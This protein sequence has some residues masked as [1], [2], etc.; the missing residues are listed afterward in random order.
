MPDSYI[1]GLLGG[2]LIGLGSL[3]AMIASGK[4]PGISGVFGRLLRP[5]T[6]DKSWRITFL[7]GLVSGAF[8]LFQFNADAARFVIPGGRSLI[9]FAI[10]GLVVGFGTRLGGGCTSGHGVCGMGMGVKDSIVATFVF[11]AAGFVTVFVFNLFLSA[12]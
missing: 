9:V 12:S 11:M 4:V 1:N 3:L 8:L 6:K 7:L 5:S 2:C 10:A